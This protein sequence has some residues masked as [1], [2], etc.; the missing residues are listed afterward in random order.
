MGINKGI[1]SLLLTQI[2]PTVNNAIS[3][4]S[5]YGGSLW[6]ADPAYTFTRSDGTGV[7]GDGSDAGYVRDLC[8]SYGSEVIPANWASSAFSSVNQGLT[9]TCSIDAGADTATYTLQGIGSTTYADPVFNLLGSNLVT[10]GGET[11]EVNAVGFT[12]AITP[13]GA[14]PRLQ[15][16]EMTSDGTYL[17]GTLIP[18][19]SKVVVTLGSDCKLV[20]VAVVLGSWS[21]GTAVNATFTLQK[22]SLRQLL[23]RPLFQSTTSFKPKLKRVPKKLGPELIVDN[24]FGGTSGWVLG[25]GFSIAGGQLTANAVAMNQSAYRQPSDSTLQAGKS[26]QFEIVCSSYTS[27]TY[28]LLATGGANPIG[29]KTSAGTFTGV[30]NS[31]TAG[32]VYVWAKQPLTAVFDSISVREVLE[33]GWAWVFDGTD[34]VL[35]TVSQPTAAAETL[36]IC[37]DVS[38][39]AQTARVRIEKAD[40]T[41]GLRIYGDTA[42][43]YALHYAA[44]GAQF[45]PCGGASD[46]RGVATLRVAAGAQATRMNGVQSAVKFTDYVSGALP[47][48]IGNGIYG[49]SAMNVFAAAYSP[50]AIPNAELLI[51]EQALG[52]LAG[53][54]L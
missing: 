2:Y 3:I 54:T 9:V 44:A 19:G 30:L 46:K 4:L 39:A 40:S 6:V 20:R 21:A 23:G 35:S 24:S 10:N 38:A 36:I 11:F 17:R 52:Q 48:K 41:T 29:D 53:L 22:P 13:A 47:V 18:L 15:L 51:V 5:K 16:A 45:T 31:A 8:T 49:A 14:V 32:A 12:G 50:V 28:A 26:Y 25:S 37:A 34:D 43:F 42:F 7:A 33:W 1:L 27:G